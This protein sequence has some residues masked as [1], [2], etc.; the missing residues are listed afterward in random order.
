MKK[1]E[2]YV[3]IDNEET[4]L[5]AIQ[6]LNDANEDWYNGISQLNIFKK[7]P[8]LRFDGKYWYL[9]TVTASCN[10]ISFDTLEQLLKTSFVV[11]EVVLPIEELRQQ[12][13][14]LG[15]E[16]V[17]KKREIKVGDFGKFWGNHEEL[18]T[19]YDFIS[20][21]NNQTKLGTIY[22]TSTIESFRNFRHLTD[23]EKAQI[24]KNW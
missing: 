6:I 18:S 2:I 20:D 19:H 22:C 4:Q 21:R 13:E 12:A 23:A 10:Q 8:Y 3:V 16:L 5:K 24:T 15:F 1:E 7:Y 9:N 14:S 17:E 11:E